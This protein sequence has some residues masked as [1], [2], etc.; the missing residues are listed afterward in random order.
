M[1]NVDLILSQTQQ[2]LPD[3]LQLART[4]LTIH[5]SDYDSA[6]TNFLVGN[7]YDPGETYP[8]P[9]RSMVIRVSRRRIDIVATK[10]S[11]PTLVELKDQIGLSALGQLIGYRKLFS[12]LN[13]SYPPASLLAV[14][15]SIGPDVG[16]ALKSA[17]VNYELVP[18]S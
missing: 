4:W 8:A 15:W 13:P 14:G 17:G 9:Y 5:S 2:L 16:N 12:D 7:G 10:G 18:R 3:E 11:Q 1:L 6:Q